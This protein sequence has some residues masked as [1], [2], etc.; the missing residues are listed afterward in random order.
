MIKYS[1]VKEKLKYNI[2]N[3]NDESVAYFTHFL[4]NS[5]TKPAPYE[6]QAVES[7]NFIYRL[8][9]AG[10]SAGAIAEINSITSKCKI[11]DRLKALI[12][13]GCQIK[14]EKLENDIFESN[15]VLIDSFLPDILAEMVLLFFSSGLS[16][17]ED[18]T[19]N[20]ESKNP[21]GYSTVNQHKFYEYKI[22]KFLAEVALGMMPAKIW[23]GICD[24][25]DGC[26]A[27]KANGRV[28]R[29]H[30]RYENQFED[31]LYRNTK[32]ETAG[33]FRHD[34][35]AIYEENGHLFIKLNMQMRFKR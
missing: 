1:Q 27:S 5:E 19:R 7:T 33:S 31:Y 23:D 28:L 11:R 9:G 8:D 13:R 3:E 21:L 14:F 26:L 6:T 12:D 20:I 25:A 10:L 35:G 34:F 2:L 32:L 22:K 30:V 17:I 16:G 4:Q 24:A 29:Y 15:L 18:L